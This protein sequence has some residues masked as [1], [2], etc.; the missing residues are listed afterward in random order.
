MFAEVIRQSFATVAYEL[1]L[2]I[3]NCP[4]HPAFISN[5]K[6]ASKIKSGY[7][8]FGYFIDGKLA[9]FA[10]LTA[11]EDG[12][13]EMNDVSV[14]PEYRRFGYGHILLD[15]CK[16]K[17]KELGGNKIRLEVVE[18]CVNVKNWYAKNGFT[19][20]ATKKYEHVTITFGYMECE[21]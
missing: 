16:G 20:T 14:L 2:T 3:E 5:E 4:Y 10:S 21:L 19:Q 15:F 12:I 7:F 9:G 11:V 1:E 18:E 6:L 13:Y 17:A 8:P